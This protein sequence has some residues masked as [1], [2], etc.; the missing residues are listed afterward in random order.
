MSWGSY[1]ISYSLPRWRAA[2]SPI[3][4]VASCSIRCAAAYLWPPSEHRAP[5][6]SVYWVISTLAPKRPLSA[7]LPPNIEKSS[8]LRTNEPT[9]KP[10]FVVIASTNKSDHSGS[11]FPPNFPIHTDLS[12]QPSI[13]LS[14]K[15][16]RCLQSE[17]GPIKL[18]SRNTL[19]MSLLFKM[20][21]TIP[22]FTKYV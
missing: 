9:S 10:T 13:F 15:Y 19:D 5:A 6:S 18:T 21:S 12:T 8:T 4:N 20:H 22:S 1:D 2:T 16:L 11:D 17:K 3:P 7:V 14:P